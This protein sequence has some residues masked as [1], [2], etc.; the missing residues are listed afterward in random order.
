MQGAFPL[1]AGGEGATDSVA[2]GE[3]GRLLASGIALGRTEAF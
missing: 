3:Y 2:L 1:L